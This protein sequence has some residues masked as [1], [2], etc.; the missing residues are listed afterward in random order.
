MLSLSI[1]K[2]TNRNLIRRS[3]FDSYCSNFKSTYIVL[4][5][6][7]KDGLLGFMVFNATFKHISVISWRSDLLAEETGVLGENHRPAASH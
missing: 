2:L 4:K 6:K 1:T 7:F 5:I 3:H